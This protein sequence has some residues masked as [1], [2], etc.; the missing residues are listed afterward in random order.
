LFWRIRL[1]SSIWDEKFFASW[2]GFKYL[3]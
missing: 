3:L 2:N 1:H